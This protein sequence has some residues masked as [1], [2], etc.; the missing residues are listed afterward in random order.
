MKQPKELVV[1][2]NELIEMPVD[3]NL[4]Q[5][6]LFARIIVSIRDNPD[7]EYYSFSVKKLLEDF[8]LCDTN[9][10]HLKNAT[11][12]LIRPV[13]IKG[14]G[15]A[16]QQKAF[17]TDVD[18]D[19]KGTVQFRIHKDLKPLI[20]NLERNYTQYYF[21]NI[22]RL[23]SAYAIRIYELL[24]QYQFR[25]ERII[26]LD[27]LRLFLKISDKKY[28][29]INDF[30]RFVIFIAQKELEEKT[31]IYFDIAEIK[32][33]KKIV[34][35]KF[36]IF[37]N[38]KNKE[39]IEKE[40]LCGFLI[41]QEVQK[42]GIDKTTVFEESEI[43]KTLV[44]EYKVSKNIALKIIENVSEE[45]IRRNIEYT[46][47]EHERGNVN[48][49]VTGYLVDAIKNDY[50]H[51]VSLFEVNS[52]KKEEQARREKQLEAKRE[53]LRS[54]VSLEFSKIEKEKYLASLSETEQEELKSQIL[55]EIKL[56]SYS[57]SLL[58]KKGL[59][60][61]IAGMWIIKKIA[62]FEERRDRYIEDKLKGA[63]L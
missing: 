5:L 61:P 30:K 14:E 23:K 59:S 22:A 38:A 27:E 37:K 52:K 51:T 8:D 50:A 15:M 4:M 18:Y 34:K 9:Y 41:P 16:E 20:L 56:D 46:K 57:V 1:K 43:F 3:F 2:A 62:G 32:E 24:K 11:K 55:E 19:S 33:G 25:G 17:F 7:D 26:A 13:V 47:M 63:G 39:D 29:K 28:S 44:D 40:T 10:T 48:K 49:S 58:K 45:K 36:F 6:K 12:G 42:P 54:K 53:S 35:I 60:S 31:D 21:S